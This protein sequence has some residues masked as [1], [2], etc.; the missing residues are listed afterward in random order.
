MNA[1]NKPM[2]TKVLFRVCRN[3]GESSAD[4]SSEE[5]TR[6]D[7]SGGGVPPRCAGVMTLAEQ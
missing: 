7:K 5:R 1:D 6:K 2:F 4:T 3:R